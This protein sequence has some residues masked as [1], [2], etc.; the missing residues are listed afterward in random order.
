[1]K[2]LALLAAPLLLAQA[3][4]PPASLT[5]TS[6]DEIIARTRQGRPLAAYKQFAISVLGELPGSR[7]GAE[8]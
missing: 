8:G 2:R 5:T 3:P 6:A 1:M 4:P 7:D